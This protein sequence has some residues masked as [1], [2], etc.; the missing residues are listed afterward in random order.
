VQVR[1]AVEV[2][3]VSVVAAFEVLALP[4]FGPAIEVDVIDESGGLCIPEFLM[5][6]VELPPL[7]GIPLGLRVP[8]LLLLGVGIGVLGFA[9]DI[10]IIEAEGVLIG[11]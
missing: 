11:I 5:F 8:P 6:E 7:A 4:H 9:V 10:G 3:V 1:F 2:V